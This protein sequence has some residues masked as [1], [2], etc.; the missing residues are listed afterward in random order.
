MRKYTTFGIAALLVI[1]GVCT[2]PVNAVVEERL[3]NM[4]GL[5]G[6]YAYKEGL[7]SQFHDHYKPLDT[8]LS[9]PPDS[10][11]LDKTVTNIGGGAF[12]DRLGKL[13]SYY[14][15]CTAQHRLKTLES[16]DPTTRRIDGNERIVQQTYVPAQIYTSTTDN[17]KRGY[18]TI[19]GDLG[20]G[21]GDQ[22]GYSVKGHLKATSYDT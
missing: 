13:T 4:G 20:T 1:A 3:A 14:P 6:D 5:T 21:T 11:I 16:G 18:S 17:Y 19:G 7:N 12:G 9:S 15:L 2:I 22:F 8:H 10:T